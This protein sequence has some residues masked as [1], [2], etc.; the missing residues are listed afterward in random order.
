M[1]AQ[2][3]SRSDVKARLPFKI[4]TGTVKKTIA[5]PTVVIVTTAHQNPSQAPE[6]NLTVNSSERAT[7]SYKRHHSL[8]LNNVFSPGPF[9]FEAG[10]GQLRAST[11]ILTSNQTTSPADVATPRI[12]NKK[13][14]AEKMVFTSKEVLVALAAMSSYTINI[15]R[16]A[17]TTGT[18]G[19]SLYALLFHLMVH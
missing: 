6:T 18:K 14:Q 16:G 13:G 1:H 2:R 15:T 17:W 12:N 5:Y 9:A 10:G 7:F 19:L 8:L 3:L 11:V 4:A